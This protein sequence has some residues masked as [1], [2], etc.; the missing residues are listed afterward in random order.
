V[1]GQAAA[2]AETKFDIPAFGQGGYDVEL[3][4]PQVQG[5]FLL[6]AIADSGHAQSPTISRRKVTLA[7]A[8]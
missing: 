8:P 3:A 5:E 4:V 1:G 6:K 2:R 7:E